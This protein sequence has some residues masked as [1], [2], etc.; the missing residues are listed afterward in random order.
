MLALLFYIKEVQYTIKCDRVQEIVPLVTLKSVPHSPD[1]FS[2]YFNYRGTIVPVIDLCR[3]INREPSALRLSTRIILADYRKHDHD[4]AHILGLIAEKVTEIVK[5]P[6]SAFIQPRI[7]SKK[8]PY[9][10]GIMMENQEMIQ[11]IELD[12]LPN[13]IDFLPESARGEDGTNDSGTD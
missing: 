1:Y 6:E 5:K 4:S 9:L 13:C 2:G 7:R 12:Q 11:Y 10:G 8:A 3:L